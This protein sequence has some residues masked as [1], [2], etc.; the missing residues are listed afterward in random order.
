VERRELIRRDL[1]RRGLGSPALFAI[2]Y[3]SVASAI[4]FSMGVVADHALGLTPFVF[5]AAGLFFVLAAMTYIE[6]ASLHQDRAGSTVFARFAFNELVS[7]VA[8]W[9]ILLDYIILIA[10]TALSATHYMAA[11]YS[12]IGNGGTRELV[13][14]LGIVLYVAVRNVRGFSTTRVK[15]IA[16]LVVA[17]LGLQVVLIV[18]GLIAFFNL[19]TLLDPIELGKYPQWSDLVFALG[20]TTVVFT[21]LESAAG[22]SGE[23]AVGRRGLK[24]LMTSAMVTVMVVYTG[25]AV[26]AM[27]ALPVVANDT[28]LARNYLEAP[29][30]GIAESFRQDWLADGL[31]Y[32]VGAAATVTLIAA[33]NSAM[34]GLSRLAY[35]LATN[36]QIP[37]WLG[38]LHP[39]RSTPMVVIGIAA[40]LAAGLVA[41]LDLE[42]LAGTFAFGALI[43]LTI[44]HVSIVVLRIRE[45][46]RPRP[47]AMPGNVTIRSA[48]IPLPAV[49][50][51]L[52]SAL[53]WVGVVATHGGAR[54]VGFAWLAG[55]LLL[56]VVYRVT[57]DK[58]L[59]KRVVVPAAALRPERGRPDTA[60]YGS[61]LVP[62]LGTALDDD[63]MQTAGRLAAEE[64]EDALDSNHGATIEAVWV[65]E[66]PMSL[67]I[68]AALPEAQVKRARAALARAKAVGEEYE[69]V[70]VATA[71]V[72]ARRAGAAIVEEARRRGV[73]AIVLAAEEPTR[74]RGGALLGGRG[75]PQE[76]FVGEITKTVVAKAPCQVILTAPPAGELPTLG[77]EVTV[78]ADGAGPDGRSSR[79]R[80]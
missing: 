8:G 76:N 50:G 32:I 26:V 67:P 5:F 49:V 62:I 40:V 35:S 21:G 9:A 16:A 52:L 30:L 57:Q 17:D 13:V 56:Y 64:D 39:T 44:A 68:D 33:A 70:E 53:A 47:Y 34:M 3:T 54:A 46:S 78:G 2:V 36:R 38:R 60:Q 11:F 31:M 71:T 74:I 72:R 12:P 66:V 41:P 73:Q 27:T 37:S 22:L 10:V 63:I 75:G 1:V 48:S 69:G 59:T 42:L 23:V 61:I 79:V 20:V 25:I 6:G 51:A 65:F 55:G 80:R 24:R 77:P 43:G 29:V 45:P 58:S 15:R 14:A 28:S 4:Y 19:D 18:L 7:F